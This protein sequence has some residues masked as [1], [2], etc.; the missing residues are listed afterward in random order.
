MTF[1][2]KIP[3]ELPTLA[4]I[5][6]IAIALSMFV[7]AFRERSNLLVVGQGAA[8]I[9]IIACGQGFVIIGAGLDL[10]VGS[11]MAMSGCLCAAAIA[12]GIPWAAAVAIGLA[13]GLAGGAINGGLITDRFP[14]PFVGGWL[15][16]AGVRSRSFPRPPILTTLAT[17]LLFRYG[18]SLLTRNRSFD[19]FDVS[20][21]ELYRLGQGAVSLLAFALVTG[22]FTLIALRTRF[23]RW[24][25]AIG[26]GE[27]A[28]R[29]SGVP[30]SAV[31]QMGYALSGLCAALSGIL[32][33]AFN[34]HAQW[35][36]GKGAELDA[37][38][39]CVVGGVRITG[40]DGSLVGAA[41][42]AILIALLQNALIL[43]GRPREQYGLFTGSVILIAAVLEQWRIQRSQKG[44]R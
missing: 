44:A 43:L 5:L 15:R 24:T 18:V 31:K 11:T 42:G 28:A 27:P 25:F 16:A 7:P 40:G 39:A 37:I 12:A 6:M 26:G 2:P 4:L 10:S 34:N 17:F 1:P 35:D 38:A 3:R 32:S 21:P 23:G 14:L 9:G 22:L 33:M 19:A 29:L 8:F 20:A 13:V 36:M 30:T 41:L